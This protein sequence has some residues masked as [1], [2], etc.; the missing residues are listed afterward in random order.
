[1]KKLLLSLF[2]VAALGLSAY[3]DTAE[4]NFKP[5]QSGSDYIYSPADCYGVSPLYTG[6]N[7][8][9]VTTNN[10]ATQNDVT[11]TFTGSNTSWRLWSDGIRA[12]KGTDATFTVAGKNNATITKVE[13]TVSNNGATFKNAAEANGGNITSWT[14]SSSSVGFVYTNTSNNY[15]LVTV[16]V[17]Y[18][19][20]V[21]PAVAQPSISF[22][23]LTNQVSISCETSG[24]SIYY[25]LNGQ[26]PTNASSKYDNPFPISATSTVKAIAYNGQDKSSIASRDCTY[27]PS[28]N[29]FAAFIAGVQAESYGIVNGP[30]TVVYQNGGYLYL[31]DNNSGYMLVYSFTA[32]T[33]KVGDVISLVYGQYSPYKGLH[34]IT[35]PEFGNVT[36]SGATVEPTLITVAE[37]EDTPINE[38]VKLVGVTVDGESLAISQGD[39]EGVLY[40]RFNGVD[41]PTGENYTIIG[42]VSVF[43]G[44]YQIYPISFEQ[45][46]SG[47][48][49]EGGGDTGEGGG[50]TGEG[51]GDTGEGGGDT[52]EG[53]GDTGEGGG[54][55]GEG[56]GNQG[57]GST[58]PETLS[59]T[60]NFADPTSLTG[61]FNDAPISYTGDEDTYNVIDVMFVEGPITFTGEAPE[62]AQNKPV[63]WYS[64]TAAN[65]AWT[66]RFYNDNTITIAAEQGYFITSISFTDQ[67]LGNES[68]TW[69]TGTF[70]NHTWTPFEDD[71]QVTELVIAKTATKNNPQISTMT[72]YYTGSSAING[73]GVEEIAPVEFYNLQGLRVANP[74]KGQLY[75]VRQGKQAKK[76]IF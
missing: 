13:W 69:S 60:F 63:L 35:D 27:A 75:I 50:D 37:I 52:G 51:G 14:G 66:Y 22:D 25:T 39:D 56:G 61:I 26:D 57:G 15:A 49:G 45:V 9:Y 53:G 8:A 3:A 32:P 4:F 7:T 10:V 11:I 5:Q 2:A 6:N 64:S 41:I 31:Q 48:T 59:V 54:D 58:E 16:K 55:T 21:A 70:A 18:T 44:T 40:K 74:V 42:F 19:P 28:F 43:S 68:I 47:D 24:S 29:S 67:N 76:V 12:Y 71:D 34:E 36:S 65:P 1:M 72:V 30:L 38:Y 46:N 33:Y 23:K 20:G 17:T 73:F 62:D